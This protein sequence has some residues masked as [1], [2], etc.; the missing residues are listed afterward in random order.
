MICLSACVQA[1]MI[2]NRNALSQGTPVMIIYPFEVLSQGP[3]TLMQTLLRVY[4]CCLAC[5][6]LFMLFLPMMIHI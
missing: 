6:L 2:S 4:L 1:V 5:R 3:N